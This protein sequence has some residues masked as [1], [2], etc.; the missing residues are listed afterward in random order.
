MA[1]G[2]LDK[3][4]AQF[5]KSEALEPLDFVPK[6]G[7]RN[8]LTLQHR[9]TDLDTLSDDFRKSPSPFQKFLGFGI[10]AWMNGARGR[11]QA[12]LD[13]WENV[14]RISA[15]SAQNRA[16]ARNRQAAHVMRSG[17][18]TAAITQAQL[19]LPD[20]TGRDQEFETL[21]ILAVANAAAGRKPESEKWLAQLATKAAVLP[22]DRET[23]RV[24][25]ARGQIAINRN[26][27]AGAANEFK[28]A[29]SMLPPYG[30]VFGPPSS[31]A[32]LL[33]DAGSAY[34]KAGRDADAAALLERL[35]KSHDAVFDTDAYARSHFLLAQIYERRKDAAKARDQYARF[36]DLWRDGDLERGW[37]ADAQKKVGR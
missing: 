4:L 32:A 8:V 27:P 1:G 9:W 3:A 26:D 17:N 20:A 25:W 5:E 6:I 35:Q 12:V 14:A 24:H 33:Y 10:S 19:A 30:P 29:V 16:F 15:I 36:L 13:A 31:V 18:L 28:L 7:R 23:R 22:S 34:I 11:G 2:Q 37:V 21:Q